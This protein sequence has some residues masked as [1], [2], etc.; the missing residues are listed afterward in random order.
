[1]S[2]LFAWLLIIIAAT[3]VVGA[4]VLLFVDVPHTTT[5]VEQPVSNE[6]LGI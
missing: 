5:R 2:R 4:A 6:T 1:M 3:I